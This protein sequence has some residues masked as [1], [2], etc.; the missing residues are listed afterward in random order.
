[1]VDGPLLAYRA[2]RRKG[3]L[4]PDPMQELAA[5][6]LQ[7]LH[8][9]LAGYEPVKGLQ[10]WAA[11]L[12]FVRRTEEPPQGLY[13]YGPVGRG[14]SML[15]DLFFEHAPVANKRRVHFHAFMIEVHDAVHAWR[16]D[17]NRKSDRDPLPQIAEQIA[18]DTWLLCFDEFH[19]TNIADAMILGRLFTALFEHGVVVVTTSNFAPDELYKNGLQRARF[20]PFIELLKQKL[21]FLEL[22]SPTDYRLARLKAMRVFHAPLGPAAS[23]TLQKVFEDLTAG[24]DAR[25]EEL[26]VKA[27][28]VPVPRAA[29]GV[30][31]FTFAGLCGE[32]LGAEDYITIAERYHTLVLDG[33]P[34]LTE[35]RRNEA[36]RFMI[37]ID[38]LYEH[39]VKLVMAADAAPHDLYKGPSHAFEFERTISRLMEMQSN[40]Y[41]ASQHRDSVE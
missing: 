34:R 37:L 7:S 1:M 19:V 40:D 31:C 32:P 23:R 15:M 28:A 36:K 17:A 9:A 4:Q 5:E 26:T 8:N 24:A 13:I 11:R 14:K 22:A 18:V 20:L 27:R 39:K 33:V 16:Q 29:R 30:A 25:P 6:K 41:L 3:D 38:T 21:D 12:G 2:L 35:D 10:G